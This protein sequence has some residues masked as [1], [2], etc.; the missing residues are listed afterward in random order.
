M[1]FSKGIL[2][3][4]ISRARFDRWLSIFLTYDCN[5]DCKHCLYKGKKGSMDLETA[6]EMLKEAK[7]LRYKSVSFSGGEPTTHPKFFDIIEYAAALGFEMDI[8]TNGVNLKTNDFL[9][10]ARIRK[11]ALTISL[12][13]YDQEKNDRLRGKG[14]Y[15]GALR[16]W[17]MTRPSRAS[18]IT[19]VT[20]ENL[21]D[22]PRTADFIFTKLGA[23]K[24]TLYRAIPQGGATE[25]ETLSKE[26][27]M[28]FY[29]NMAYRISQLY[30]EQGKQIFLGL[31]SHSEEVCSVL[32]RG[33]I[34]FPDGSFGVCCNIPQ[35]SYYRYK[36]HGDLKHFLETD[37]RTKLSERIDKATYDGRQKS[38]RKYGVSF[39]HD[40][41]SDLKK[42]KIIQ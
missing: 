24:L 41:V 38:I 12:D 22:I 16:S 21:A 4:I 7:E 20:K 39:C 23:D 5:L 42:E 17:A 30:R 36:K 1:L 37:Y 26:E 11:L 9:R 35:L 6:K 19:L 14:S 31:G 40:C 25:R 10:L 3:D 32:D 13:S 28:N 29:F 34:V 18:F 33:V 15:E 2:E 8:V 27:D